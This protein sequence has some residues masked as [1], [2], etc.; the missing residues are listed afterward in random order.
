M[1]NNGN[2]VQYNRGEFSAN[3]ILFL[4]IFS[5]EEWMLKTDVKM[6]TNEAGFDV[7]QT[8]LKQDA[9]NSGLTFT[10]DS[11]NRFMQGDST[12]LYNFAFDVVTRETGRRTY[13]LKRIRFH[14]LT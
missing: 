2:L 8:A 1:R 14:K 3:L 13:S 5:T 7:F 6:Y 4:E 9:L 10:A 11:G 12:L